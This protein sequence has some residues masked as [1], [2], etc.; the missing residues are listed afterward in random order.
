MA[1]TILK[2]QKTNKEEIQMLRKKKKEKA[3]LSKIQKAT[4]KAERAGVKL[5]SVKVK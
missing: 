3:L 4:K 1:V 5:V 2:I